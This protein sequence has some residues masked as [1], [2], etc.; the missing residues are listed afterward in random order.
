MQPRHTFYDDN[1]LIDLRFLTAAEAYDFDDDD[2]LPLLPYGIGCLL[3]VGHTP[4]RMSFQYATR[5][6]RDAA[7]ARLIAMHQ[8]WDNFLHAQHDNEGEDA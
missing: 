8:T 3:E 4:Q 7:F 2:E 5:E 1:A 6:Q